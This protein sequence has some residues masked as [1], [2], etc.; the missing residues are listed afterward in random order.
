MKGYDEP[1][2]LRSQLSQFGPIT[3]D[4]GQPPAGIWVLDWIVTILALSSCLGLSDWIE[5][6]ITPLIV[7]RIAILVVFEQITYNLYVARNS[8][9]CYLGYE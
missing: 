5:A 6:V 1:E 7:I 2:I 8:E 4:A 9:L 3:A